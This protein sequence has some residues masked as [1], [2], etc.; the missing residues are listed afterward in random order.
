MIVVLKTGATQEQIDKVLARIKKLGLKPVVSQGVERTIIGVVGE[1]DILRVQPLEA[2]EGVEKVMPVVKPYKLVSREFKPEDT[3]VEVKDVNMV[4]TKRQGTCQ[5]GETK[6]LGL[7]SETNAHAEL[8]TK[9]NYEITP[10]L[11]NYSELLPKKSE[12]SW[13][14]RFKETIIDNIPKKEMAIALATTLTAWNA[15]QYWNYSQPK[16]DMMATYALTANFFWTIALSAMSLNSR[17]RI[18]LKKD[19]KC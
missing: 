7:S 5:S 6:V 8:G 19:S 15:F 10:L 3:V 13:T 9:N 4:C 16:E 11:K 17:K 14:T 2:F 1:E 18:N 12:K